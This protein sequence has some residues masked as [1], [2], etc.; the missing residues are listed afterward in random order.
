M[1]IN[2]DIGFDTIRGKRHVLFG[3]DETDRAFLSTATAK[4]ITNPGNA[5]IANTDFGNTEAFLAFGHKG[6]ID[7]TELAFFRERRRIQ[8]RAGFIHI[9][10]DF[11]DQD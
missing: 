1:W 6:F 11:T 2:N 5:F 7:I 9:C 4:F 8:K 10:G 3:Y